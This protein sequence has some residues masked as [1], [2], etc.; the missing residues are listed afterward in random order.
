[1]KAKNITASSI[2]TMLRRLPWAWEAVVMVGLESGA[3]CQKVVRRL[4]PKG[5]RMPEP[6]AGT[7]RGGGAGLVSSYL[8]GA[9]EC[10]RR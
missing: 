2:E 3:V 10:G 4:G 7:H 6:L 9:V 5:G 8:T 1:M